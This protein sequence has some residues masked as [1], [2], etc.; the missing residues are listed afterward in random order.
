MMKDKLFVK[1]GI[2]KYSSNVMYI[3]GFLILHIPALLFSSKT[4]LMVALNHMYIR[5]HYYS[6]ELPDIKIIYKDQS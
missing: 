1:K 4:A 6:T 5:V 2:Y 3:F